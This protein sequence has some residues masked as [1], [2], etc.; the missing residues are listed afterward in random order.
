[1]SYLSIPDASQ[2]PD[3]L[4]ALV[5]DYRRIQGEMRT[6]ENELALVT[7][8][9]ETARFA[10]AQLLADAAIAGADLTAVGTPNHDA[11]VARLA[12]LRPVVAGLHQAHQRLSIEIQQKMRDSAGP[13]IELAKARA[14]AQLKPYFKAIEQVAQAAR[15]F[16]ATLFLLAGWLT[17]T[18]SGGKRFGFGTSG[19]IAVGGA[20]LDPL[21]IDQLTATLREHAGR[22]DVL[23][24]ALAKATGPALTSSVKRTRETSLDDDAQV[25]AA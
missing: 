21:R 19:A 24:K 23:D 7:G 8:G 11:R 20:F 4:A 17:L 22:F 3:D 12:E 15:D 9:A 1:M 25:W 18:E 2:L 16:D 6:A 5:N 10:D 14:R 13:G